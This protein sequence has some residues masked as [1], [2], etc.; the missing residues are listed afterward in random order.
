MDHAYCFVCK[1]KR[2]IMDAMRVK[3]RNRKSNTGHIEALRGRC[4]GC[5]CVLYRIIGK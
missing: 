3:L 1:A 5:G 2:L 4:D